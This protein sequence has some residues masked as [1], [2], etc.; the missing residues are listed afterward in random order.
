[1]AEAFAVLQREGKCEGERTEKGREEKKRDA[2]GS[3]GNVTVALSTV[4]EGVSKILNE[5]PR[6]ARLKK[7]DCVARGEKEVLVELM[8]G[9]VIHDRSGMGGALDK[10]TTQ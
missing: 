8:K 4:G 3:V 7:G 10:D 2:V 1:M 5:A 9:R 6:H